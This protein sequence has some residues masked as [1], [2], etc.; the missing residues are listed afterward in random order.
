MRWFFTDE[1]TIRNI[2]VEMNTSERNCRKTRCDCSFR[3]ARRIETV[4]SYIRNARER[5]KNNRRVVELKT[6]GR[7][8]E[9]C[10]V[11]RHCEHGVRERSIPGCSC[12]IGL[13]V[14]YV[15]PYTRV[16]CTCR[17]TREISVVSLCLMNIL[18]LNRYSVTLSTTEL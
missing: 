14:R 1:T 18:T 10:A 15:T 2:T 17:T 5:C 6:V 4:Q 13:H 3:R 11:Q 9:K 7:W 12:S 16:P 8:R